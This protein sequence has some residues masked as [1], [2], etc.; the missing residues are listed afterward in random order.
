MNYPFFSIIIP[1]FNQCNLLKKALQSVFKQNFKS[2][3]IIVIDNHS[4]DNTYKV[5]KSFKKKIIYSKIKNFGSI[6]KSRNIG[7]KKSHG[8][9]LAF[10]DSDDTW[11]DNKLQ[12]IY[13]IINNNKAQVICH[14]E[15]I[16]RNDKIKK[17]L[18]YGPYQKN[19]YQ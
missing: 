9:W 6:G 18:T 7:I 14:A 16:L 17:L 5:I 1:T 19:F 2:Y 12:K 4:T 13:K 15:W 11:S 10:L 8:K 3:E